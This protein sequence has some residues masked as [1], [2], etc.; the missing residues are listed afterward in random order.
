MSHSTM[1]PRQFRK[2]RFW[3]GVPPPL[4]STCSFFQWSIPWRKVAGKQL[5]AFRLH[6]GYNMRFTT[7]R[8]FRS[9]QR[10][11]GP[12]RKCARPMTRQRSAFSRSVFAPTGTSPTEA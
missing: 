10:S 7:C 6:D 5:C 8:V 4:L 1:K 2:I 11:D 3:V 12:R 9:R